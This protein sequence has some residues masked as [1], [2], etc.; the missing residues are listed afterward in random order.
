MAE[1]TDRPNVLLLM[2]DQWRFDYL[3]CAGATWVKT[4]NIDELASRGMRFT[5]CHVNSPVCTPSRISLA[6]GLLPSR[7]GHVNNRTFLP[8]SVPTYYQQLRDHQHFVGCVGKVDLAKADGYNG[9]K[10]NRPVAFS[11]GF[12]HPYECEGKMHAGQGGG[13]VIGPYTAYLK[14][15]GTLEAFNEDYARRRKEGYSVSAHDSVL[16]TRQF[17]DAFIGRRAARWIEQIPGDFP[18]HLFV[19]FVGPHDPFD[20]PSEYATRYRDAAMPDPIPANE[21]GKPAWHKK[22]AKVH[23]SETVRQ[24][25]RQYCA[26][27]ELIDAEVGEI[28]QSL[29]KRG[30]FDNTYIIF[31]SDHGEMLGDHGMYTKSVMY[32]PS[33]RVP[34]IVSGPGIEKGVANDTFVEL[35]DLNPT[36]CELQGVKPLP[37]I[38]ARSFMPVLKGEKTEHRDMVVSELDNCRMARNKQFKLVA[39]VNDTTELYD[40]K[41]DPD[42]QVNLIKEKPEAAGELSRAMSKRFIGNKWHR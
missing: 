13:K 35:M 36:I 30:Q 5:H 34:L 4:P 10:G 33:V 3:G 20:P 7:M 37:K 41:N 42:E 15:K 28:I 1:N 2:A 18:W 16:P 11:W 14:R 39:N 40:M 24:T 32:D 6:S 9:E 12:T 31:T 38:D 19:S 21:N 22:R 8:S 27:I 23:S 17:E 26:A 29:K 25:R